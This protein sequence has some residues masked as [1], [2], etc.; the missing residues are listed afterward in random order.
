VSKL[1]MFVLAN[2][3]N[4]CVYTCLM[5]IQWDWCLDI[6]MRSNF[7]IKNFSMKSNLSAC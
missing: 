4:I 1:F 7:S 5:L 3:V 2:L 6:S